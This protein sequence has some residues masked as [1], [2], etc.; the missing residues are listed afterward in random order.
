M[1]TL[2][3]FAIISYIIIIFFFIKESEYF[4]MLALTLIVSIFLCQQKEVEGLTNNSNSN[5][6]SN[7]NINSKNFGS[8]GGGKA[9]SVLIAENIRKMPPTKLIKQTKVD[10]AP[11]DLEYKIGPYDGLCIRSLNKSFKDISNNKLTSNDNL[12][13]YLGV[14]GP[15]Q[16]IKTDNTLLT[17]PTVDGEKGTSQR[18][19]MFANNEASLNCC[20]STYSTS[21]GCVCMTDKQ[22]NFI[23]TR[24]KNNNQSPEY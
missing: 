13:N 12:M 18:L 3:L 15:T 6:N 16:N 10:V 2:S 8:A 19:F 4:K 1:N 7:S 9:K 20:P 24:G 21:T 22:T 14:Q 23:N 11:L 5:S 17:G